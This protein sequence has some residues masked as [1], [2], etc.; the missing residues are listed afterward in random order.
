MSNDSFKIDPVIR[1]YVMQPNGKPEIDNSLR[2]PAFFRLRIPR[3]KWLY[4]PDDNYGS[5]YYLLKKN[6]NSSNSSMVNIGLKAL[7][8]FVD[9]DRAF[10]TEVE[11]VEKSRSGVGL[12]VK[13]QENINSEPETVFVP[14]GR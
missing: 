11:I 3:R 4:A 12:E 8:S 2:T 1:D 9:E 14:I 7:E 5:D 6:L 10:D 13:I